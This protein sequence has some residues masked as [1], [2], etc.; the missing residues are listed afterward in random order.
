MGRIEWD[1][2][3]CMQSR[4]DY[5]TAVKKNQRKKRQVAREIAHEVQKRAECHV[6]AGRGVLIWPCMWN[7]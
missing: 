1:L 6:V 7:F 5:T 3:D 2:K 4:Q